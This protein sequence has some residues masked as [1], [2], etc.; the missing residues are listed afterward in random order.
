MAEPATQEDGQVPDN[1]TAM[2]GAESA[3]NLSRKTEGGLSL[4]F[5]FDIPKLPSINAIPTWT[6]QQMIN[7][8]L[9]LAVVF[10]AGFTIY[11]KKFSSSAGGYEEPTT[12][13]LRPNV[14][15]DFNPTLDSP[16]IEA[17]A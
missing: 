5:S 6:H 1:V 17:G 16:K 8:A 14:L 15:T 13:L 4:R 11:D 2:P 3:V 12:G 10:L 9:L 7:G